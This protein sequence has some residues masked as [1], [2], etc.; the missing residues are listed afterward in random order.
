MAIKNN[1]ELQNGITVDGAYCR[2]ENVEATKEKLTFS[3]RH[4]VS[5]DKPFF[6]EDRFECA[7]DL[8]GKNVF[9]Q[10][11]THLKSLDVYKSS[12]DC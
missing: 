10:A 4:Y 8:G 7:H 11:Y 9:I 12:V 3:L 5:T 1:V 6:S 2:V